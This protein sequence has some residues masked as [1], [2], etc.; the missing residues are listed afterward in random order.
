MDLSGRPMLAQQLR[1]VKL[2]K[3]VNEIVVATTGRAI[4][5]PII[6]L[7][8]QEG[9]LCYRGSEND[10]I[11][12]FIGAARLSKADVVVRMTA[13]CPLVDPDVADRIIQDLVSGDS[14]Y[15]YASNVIQRTYPRGLDVEAFFIDTLLR[16]DRMALSE[17]AREHVTLFIYSERPDLFL[18]HSV[19]DIENNSDLRWTVDTEDDLR[20]IHTVYDDLG[21][22]ERIVPYREMVEYIRSH[23]EL[24]EINK[25]TDTWTPPKKH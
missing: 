24:I 3:N 11:S 6:D 21:L 18:C 1:R 8:G 5:D 16:V 4:D 17:K 12:R 20:F 15:D 9:V 7:S 23:P 13:D 22:N 25:N 14:Q 19:M 10:V 2:C